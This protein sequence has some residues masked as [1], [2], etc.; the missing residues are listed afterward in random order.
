MDKAIFETYAGMEG[1]A[2]LEMILRDF[3]D[4]AAVVSSFGAGGGA[5]M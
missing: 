1:R 3:K 2:L 4:R 5:V